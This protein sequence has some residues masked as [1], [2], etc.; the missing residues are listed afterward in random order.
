MRSIA[1]TLLV[2]VTVLTTTVALAACGASNSSHGGTSGGG[3]QATGKCASKPV[4]VGEV[5]KLGTDPY[6]VTVFH[7]MQAAAKQI[8]GGVVYTSPSDASGPAQIPFVEQ[9][10]AQHVGAIAISGSDL[11]A[12]AAALKKAMAQGIRVVSFDSDVAP[13]ARTLFLNPTSTEQVA[14]AELNSMYQLIGG[15]GDFDILSTTPTAVNQNQRVAITKN[16]LAHDPKYSHMHLVSIG[17]GYEKTD[18]YAQQTLALASADPNL[19]GIIV[20]DGIGLP[21]AA[22][23]L[24]RAGLLGKIKLTGIAPPSELKKYIDSG[25]VQDVW[26]NVP[27]LGMLTY[28]AAQALA[29]C[30]ITGAQGQTFTAGSLGTFKVGPQGVVIL[31]QAVMVTPKNINQFPF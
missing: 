18:V 25:N 28:Y 16:A 21:A 8:G 15:Q 13:D 4:T 27:N 14:L 6:M 7:G 31:Q 24:S 17:Y 10:I 11:Y 12:A 23:A 2:G 22:E 19:K 20:P 29:E 30:K 5:P 3:A 1:R 26:W 9:L